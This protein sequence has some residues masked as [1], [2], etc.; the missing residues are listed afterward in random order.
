MDEFERQ[1]INAKQLP[2]NLKAKWSERVLQEG[3]VAFPKR[4]LR[5]MTR[6]FVGEG[7]VPNL[8]VVLA[9]V[10]HR[11]PNP[12]RGPSL[13]YLAFLSGM[14]P[15]QVEAA[16]ERLQGQG[17]LHCLEDGSGRL[18]IDLDPLFTAIEGATAEGSE[19]AD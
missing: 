10:D 18:E 2:P 12:Q 17:L 13:E 1:H 7:G 14:E 4:L 9:I 11:R 5:C 3:F 19:D 8:A 6:F 16:L 15:A